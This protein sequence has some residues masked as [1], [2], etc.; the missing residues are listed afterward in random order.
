V[1]NLHTLLLVVE[2]LRFDGYSQSGSSQ[3]LGV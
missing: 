3:L 1:L 2:Q